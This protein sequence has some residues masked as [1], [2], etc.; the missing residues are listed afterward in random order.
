QW[1]DAQEFIIGMDDDAPARYIDD[2]K[3]FLLDGQAPVITFNEIRS[4]STRN[5]RLDR[6]F[7]KTG[8]PELSILLANIGM[9]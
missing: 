7:R 1:M 3:G 9:E 2:P 8:A 6:I 5:L 4:T